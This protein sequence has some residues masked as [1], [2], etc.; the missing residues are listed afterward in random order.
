MHEKEKE[1]KRRNPLN[2]IPCCRE[3]E[4]KQQVI[5]DNTNACVQT[6]PFSSVSLI[7]IIGILLL[8]SS[9]GFTC[10]IS[11]PVCH[12][13]K[14]TFVNF[15]QRAIALCSPFHRRAFWALASQFSWHLISLD[16]LRRK[17][18]VVC[19]NA[20]V[21]FTAVALTILNKKSKAADESSSAK[22]VCV[23]KA[24]LK[25]IQGEDCDRGIPRW[26]VINWSRDLAC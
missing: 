20:L 12:K 17:T 19:S 9:L 21:T 11:I 7:T 22:S 24:T 5:S 18:D 23:A 10:W 13:I 8:P 16:S 4:S 3:V 6:W 14:A 2:Q 15:R 25:G 1:K 26:A